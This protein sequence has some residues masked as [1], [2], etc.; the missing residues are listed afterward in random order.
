M[1]NGEPI[2]HNGEATGATPGTML[3]GP[4][5]EFDRDHLADLPLAAE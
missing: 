5:M 2:I 1:V 3:S 4:G